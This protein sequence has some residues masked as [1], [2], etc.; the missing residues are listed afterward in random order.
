METFISDIFLNDLRK[1]FPEHNIDLTPITIV[2]KT[3]SPIRKV[4]INNHI[5]DS[6]IYIEHL[7][8][9]TPNQLRAYCDLYIQHI[10]EFYDPLKEQIKIIRK[11]IYE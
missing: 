3:L 6:A 1:V 5:I 4:I 10:E 8:K 11:E 7:N 2:E 9:F